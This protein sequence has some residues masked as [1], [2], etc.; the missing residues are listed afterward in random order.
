MRRL[1]EGLVDFYRDERGDIVQTAIIVA[2][3]ATIAIGGLVFLGPKIKSN[4]TKTGNEL[5][6]GSNFGY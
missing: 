3:M 5:D 1:K 4:F 2:I 6:T